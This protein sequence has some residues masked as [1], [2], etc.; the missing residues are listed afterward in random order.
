VLQFGRFGE[1][2]FSESADLDL[3]SCYR[4]RARLDGN[5]RQYGRV[6]I[7]AVRASYRQPGSVL[8]PVCQHLEARTS[9][10][11]HRHLS[12]SEPAYRALAADRATFKRHPAPHTSKQ[13]KPL[14]GAEAKKWCHAQGVRLAGGHLYAEKPKT[15][16]IPSDAGRRVA[17]VKDH[18]ERRRGSK[19]LV[20]FDQWGVWPSGE[21]MH[22]FVETICSAGPEC[23]TSSTSSRRV[24]RP[25]VERELSVPVSDDEHKDLVSFLAIGV[26]FLGDFEVIG[27]R[28]KRRGRMARGVVVAMN[29]GRDWPRG[30]TQ[31][32]RA[33]PAA[34]RSSKTLRRSAVRPI[35]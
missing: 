18:L 29:G 30:S 21:R 15:F 33:T 24:E 27:S 20:R 19:T 17:L 10:A 23:S 34:R 9:D 25:V 26:L 2:A 6:S 13:M 12:A 35:H 28:A 5:Y 22:V 11:C 14:T 7:L 3:P 31:R 16:S 8:S 4:R 32:S 1:G